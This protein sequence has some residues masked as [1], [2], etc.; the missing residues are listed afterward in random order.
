MIQLVL[1]TLCGIGC[2]VALVSVVGAL[3]ACLRQSIQG[4]PVLTPVPV[5]SRSARA[6]ECAFLPFGLVQV[7]HLAERLA[8]PSQADDEVQA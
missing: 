1:I 7:H 3:I 4:T 2:L 6:G 8:M 5:P